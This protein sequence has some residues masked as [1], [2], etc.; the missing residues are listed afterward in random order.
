LSDPSGG[1]GDALGGLHEQQQYFHFSAFQTF[2]SKS[3]DCVGC[4]SCVPWIWKYDRFARSL[5]V[6]VSALQQFN[7]LG[8]D[9]ISYT[10]SIDT[11]TPMGRL[12][13][14]I[15]C[16][17]AEFEKEMIVERVRAGLANARA[18][19][20]RLGRPEK[21]PTAAKRIIKLREK[22]QSLRQIARKEN[23]SAAGVLKIL[24]R[25]P[26]DKA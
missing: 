1:Q 23:L 4:A 14:Y 19:G 12:F 6:L 10:Q 2:I 21:D 20:V 11:T 18:K 13:Y 26:A 15:I 5:S 17:F 24:R 22:G 8:V 16:S 9:F 3:V 7:S 25:S